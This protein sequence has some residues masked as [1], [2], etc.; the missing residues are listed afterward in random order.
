MTTLCE[1]WA[2]NAVL[3]VIAFGLMQIT[4]GEEKVTLEDRFR[5][6]IAA[7]NDGEIEKKPTMQHS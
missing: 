7:V 6:H 1:R 5:A 3:L 2:V 4:N